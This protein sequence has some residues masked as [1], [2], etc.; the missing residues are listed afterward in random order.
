MKKKEAAAA[1]PAPIE[2]LEVQVAAKHIENG[3]KSFQKNP[4]A[5]A[6][7]EKYKFKFISAGPDLV[8]TET[9]KYMVKWDLR[10]KL[11]R[12]LNGLGLEPY[13]VKYRLC[14]EIDIENRSNRVNPQSLKQLENFREAEGGLCTSKGW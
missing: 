7:K 10:E 5:L 8:Y 12:Y 3:D 11:G 9:G 6:L 1:A 14:N 2:E 4:V 13:T